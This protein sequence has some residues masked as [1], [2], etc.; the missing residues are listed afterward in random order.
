MTDP[1]K[2]WKHNDGDWTVAKKFDNYLNCYQTIFE[3]CNSIPWHIIPS[4]K[5]W[6]KSYLIAKKI[7][8]TL[9]QLDL[10]WPLLETKMKTS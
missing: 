5:N 6:Y 7:E 10:K 3:K 8:E 1:T 2:F 9:L 4:D